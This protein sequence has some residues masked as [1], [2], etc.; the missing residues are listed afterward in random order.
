MLPP[1]SAPPEPPPWW[2]PLDPRRSLPA[3]ATLVF[4]G[5][6]LALVLLL[7]GSAGEIL[8]RQIERQLGPSFENLAHQVGDKLDRTLYERT[9]QLQFTASLAPFR[10]VTAPVAERH[11]VLES[12]HDASPDYAWVGFADATGTVLA[13]SQHLFE[14]AKATGDAWFR[15]ARRQPFVGAVREFPALAGAVPAV[16]ADAPRFLDLAVPV[17]TTNGQF[18]GVLGAH[19]RWSWARDVQL[20][21]VPDAARREHLGVTIYAATGE[22]ILDS[23]GSGW[24]EPPDAP[25]GLSDRPGTRGNLTEHA[26]GGTV[27]LTG[28]A[29]TR[30]FR[31]YRGAGW[32]VV[33]RQPVADAFAP[34]PELRASILHAGLVLVVA[35]GALSWIFA[36]RIERRLRAV[37]TAADRIGSGDI[38]SLMPRPRGDS[39][40]AR[41]C[42]ALGDMVGKFRERQESLEADNARLRDQR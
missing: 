33:V 41:M 25:P 31:D 35:L 11:A 16:G 24:S 15:G 17:N 19:V 1:A 8:H 4:G 2:A 9:R 22:V 37:A 5:A 26:A 7:A 6:A 36:A 14:G 32:L 34:V 27:Y 40:L 10:D 20:S 21:V 23:G 28:Y 39:Q 18:L 38:L 13:A 30:G 29:R 3:R 12:L 42:A